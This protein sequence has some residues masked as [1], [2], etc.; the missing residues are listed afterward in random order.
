MY[1]RGGM[2]E[3]TWTRATAGGLG[4]TAALGLTA[5][6]EADVETFTVA[7]TL[8]TG[9]GSLRQAISQ[10]NDGDVADSDRIVFGAKVSGTIG[11]TSGSLTTI[12]E[13]LAISGPGASKLTVNGGA[14]AGVFVIDTPGSE[15]VTISGLTLT[16]QTAGNGAA[17]SNTDADLTLRE[18]IV[19]GSTAG[20]GE[21][22]AVYSESGTLTV[23]RSTIS[24]NHSE[25]GYG[26]GIFSRNGA[27]V[28]DS[29]TISGNSTAG[30]AASIGGGG[31]IWTYGENATI[32]NSTITGNV[33]TG[34]DTGGGGI[35]AGEF[36]GGHLTVEN[37]TVTGNAAN[38]GSG[39]GI[40]ADD[41]SPD[42]I[43]TIVAGN[44]AAVSGPDLEGFGGGTFNLAF[45]LVGNTAGAPITNTVAGSNLL[46]KDPKL[47][48]LAANGGSTPTQA[49]R[50]GSPAINKG[51]TGGSSACAP[52]DQRGLKRA[53][54]CDIGAYERV[55]CAGVA[56]NRIGTPR[57]DRLL[58]TG[59]RDGILGLGGNDVLV[60]RS[61]NDGLCGAAG[62]D[63]LKGGKG[64]D[65]LKGGKGRD[66]LIGGPGIDRLL[67]GPGKDRLVQ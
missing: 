59:G 24:N 8:D 60:G 3:G 45:S 41:D 35:Y 31:G 10:S 25:G 7:N 26:G 17:I 64:K 37:S 36:G 62:K 4:L 56:V 15:D 58:G 42:L 2:G 18:A 27:L 50:A 54:R 67:G 47:A 19:T 5:T 29:S 28:V 9:A 43:N 33:L 23:E 51:S 57:R 6:A 38:N 46:G 55:L 34:N 49:L 63:K 21:G 11:L 52:T 39:G 44:S 65:R 13:P 12:D 66:T 1:S 20:G 40:E 22:G 16:G 61:G 32:R 30:N 53:G 48:P 14:N